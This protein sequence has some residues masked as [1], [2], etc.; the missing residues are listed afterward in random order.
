MLL[1]HGY[2]GAGPE[3]SSSKIER[4]LQLSNDTP[5]K[6]DAGNINL[7]VANPSTPAQLFHLLR[8]QMLRNYRKPL[9]VASP[10][11]LLR[12]PAA[13]SPLSEMGLGTS[14]QPVMDLDTNPH[15]PDRLI[16]CSGKHFYTL[17]EALA[18]RSANVALVRIEELSP[19]PRND[20]RAVLEKYNNAEMVWAQE[21]PEN[22]GPWT[23]VRPRIEDAM[24]EAGVDG[25]LLYRGRQSC[26]TVAVG[27]GSWHKQEVAQLVDA[28]FG[29]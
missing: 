21:E 8:R 9:I 17:S 23:F 27:V 26:A 4:F 14:F 28:A 10:K 7:I 12:A 22:Q 25:P 15:S 1:P 16:L 5:T 11:G 13:A 6:D 29:A 18:S 2:D 24:R 20:L 3:H 19:F